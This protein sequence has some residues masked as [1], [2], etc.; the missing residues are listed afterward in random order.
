MT[1]Y[2]RILVFILVMILVIVLGVFAWLW[3]SNRKN[4]DPLPISVNQNTQKS[5]DVSTPSSNTILHI[6]A[7]NSLK[8][9]LTD[10][11]KKFEERYLSVQVQVQ[12]VPTPSLL[13]LKGA[14]EVDTVTVDMVITNSKMTQAQLLPLQQALNN[15][16]DKRNNSTANADKTV[17]ASTETSSAAAVDRDNPEAHQIVSFSYAIKDDKT[18]DGVILTDNPSAISL[19][20]FLLGSSGQDILKKY[21]YSDIDGYKN[22]MDDLFNPASNS[23][24][25]RGEPSVKVADALSNGN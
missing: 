7:E 19:R 20:N 11:I 21:G 4:T 22:S 15:T 9:P 1:D 6:R 8:K 5:D 2:K 25:A 23:K 24:S 10:L 3:N 12:Y 14:S 17:K 18:V 13:T 16:Q